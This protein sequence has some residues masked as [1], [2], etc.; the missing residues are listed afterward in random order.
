MRAGPLMGG[1]EGGQFPGQREGRGWR[2]EK[3]AGRMADGL[4]LGGRS[5]IHMVIISHGRVLFGVT[6]MTR[7]PE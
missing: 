2:L 5:H 6:K 7:W 1:V 4:F 3:I